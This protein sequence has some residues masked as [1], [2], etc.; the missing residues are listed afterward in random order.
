MKNFFY[1]VFGGLVIILVVFLFIKVLSLRGYKQSYNTKE[2]DVVNTTKDLWLATSTSAGPTSVIG[3]SAYIA[4]DIENGS[5]IT[6]K[7]PEV[8]K[9]IASL[10]KLVTAIVA[11]KYIQPDTKINISNQILSTY[12]NTAGFKA[13]ETF[14]AN[15]LLYPL[16]MVSSNDAAEALALSYGRSSFIKKMNDFVS[17]IGAYRTYFADPSGL[18]SGSVSTAKDIA[19][20]LGWM[21]KNKPNLLNITLQQTKTTRTHTWVNPTHFL[22]WSY[23]IGGKNGYLP[24]A[25]RTG[26]SLFKFSST[27]PVYAVVVLGSQSRD[28]DVIS[29]ISK[30]KEKREK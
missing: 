26:A 12:G 23:Y 14:L 7:N 28:S 4:M 10:A 25:N 3:A 30:L 19:I 1:I 16:L 22:S 9:P 6:A 27:T 8:A 20:I 5:V 13:G 2:E 24:D 15:D 17:S 11:D 21:Y 29:I 18:S